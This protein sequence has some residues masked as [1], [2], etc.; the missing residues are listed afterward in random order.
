MTEEHLPS[1]GYER[2]EFLFKKIQ[3]HYRKSGTTIQKAMNPCRKW[4][5][6]PQMAN[7]RC[8]CGVMLFPDCDASAGSI[9]E[10]HLF[11]VIDKFN[12]DISPSITINI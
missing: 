4:E 12:V 3:D 7:P 6:P 8:R 2:N 10:S 9:K 1:K 11:H 5:W